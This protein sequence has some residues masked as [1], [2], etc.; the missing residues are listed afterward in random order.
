MQAVFGIDF[1][2][3]N[4]ALSVYRNGTVEVV[5]VDGNDRGGELMRSVLYF[6]EENEIYVGHEAIRQYVS[7]GAAGRFMQSIKTFLPNTSFDSTEVFGKRYT[8]DDLVAI[9]L[10]KIKARGE[11]HAG[12]PV[13]SVVLGRPVLFSTDAAKD[14]IAE[15]RLEKAA[16]K[17]GFKNI[18]KI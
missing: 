9:I 4:S 8:I 5:A 13:E 11:E 18:H 6:S 7:D 14:A 2:T 3:T 10:S 1:G 17:A 12:S 15:Q 16:R